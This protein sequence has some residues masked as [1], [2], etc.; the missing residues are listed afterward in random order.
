MNIVTIPKNE[1]KKLV[2]NQKELRVRVDILQKVIEEKLGEGIRPEVLKRIERRSKAMEGGAGIKL[3][4]VKE[5]RAFFR[6]L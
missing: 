5:I 1:Y 2:E 4:S 3:K 6:S